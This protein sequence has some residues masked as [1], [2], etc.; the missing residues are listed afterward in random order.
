MA[1]CN[2]NK[3]LMSALRLFFFVQEFLLVQKICTQL[4][5]SI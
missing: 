5:F 1:D 4:V 3:V 2:E